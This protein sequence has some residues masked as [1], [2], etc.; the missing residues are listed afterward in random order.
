ME[1]RSYTYSQFTML[2]NVRISE[3][4]KKKRFLLLSHLFIVGCYSCFCCSFLNRCSDSVRAFNKTIYFIFFFSSSLLYSTF[5]SILENTKIMNYY[6]NRIV[7][8]IFHKRAY[9]S[10]F[11]AVELDTESHIWWINE[12]VRNECPRKENKWKCNAYYYWRYFVRFVRVRA[13][14]QVQSEPNTVHRS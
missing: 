8:C 13:W 5:R 11:F 2:W 3:Q 6:R 12:I 4:T 9:I 10:F 1:F 14:V 7:I